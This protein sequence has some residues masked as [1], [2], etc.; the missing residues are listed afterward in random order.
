M[1]NYQHVGL[2]DSRPSSPNKKSALMS[3]RIGISVL[4]FL[5]ISATRV[6]AQQSA[7]ARDFRPNEDPSITIPRISQKIE[8]DGI[9]DDEG[10]RSASHADNFCESYP[11]DCTKP[12]FDMWAKIAYD[13]EN[14]YVSFKLFEDPSNIRRSLSER[15]D[16]WR[17]DYFALVLDT[18]GNSEWAYFLAVNPLGIQGDERMTID[19][20]DGS[21]DVIFKSAGMVT[22]DGYQIEMAIPFK[23]LRYPQLDLQKWKINFYVTQPRS[24]RTRFSWYPLSRDNSCFMCQ[25]GEAK[26][27]QG[28]SVG[29]NVQLLPAITSS[30]GASLRDGD[31]PSSGIK[32]EKINLDP[33]LGIKYGISPNLNLDL[34]LNPD[35][36][37]I[38]AD[39]SQVD[40]NTTF[41][42]FFDERRPFF[43]EGSDLFDT[44]ISTVYT[45]SINNPAFAA[46]LTGRYDKVS[47]GY[48]GGRDLDSPFIIPFEENSAVF[49]GGA[50]FSNIFR[51]KRSLGEGSFLGG[52][53][54]DRRLDE[55]GSGSTFGFD[56]LKRLTSS[57]S[58]G[59]HLVGSYTE[60]PDSPELSENIR[61]QTFGDGYTSALDGETFSGLG[62]SIE[63]GNSGRNFLMETDIKAF[64]PT[65]RVDN[66]FERQNS[67]YGFTTFNAYLF[68]PG[69]SWITTVNPD[70]VAG[71]DWNWDGE[72]K[73]RFFRPGIRLNLR[74][75]TFIGIR[76][77][78]VND[79]KFAGQ[80]FEGLR[81]LSLFLDSSPN[82]FITLGGDADFGPQISRDVD[83]PLKG[84]SLNYRFRSTV[85]PT[86]QLRISPSFVYSKLD[87]RATGE[88]IFSGYIFR[89]R[90]D[91][92]ASRKL[93][94]RV[95]AE[96]NNFSDSFAL[97]PLVTY[98]INAF[99]AVY[100]GST[101]DYFNFE[102]PYGISQSGR[103]FFFK[104]Q[105]LL[106]V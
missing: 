7:D 84:N 59:W 80:T 89:S 60:E 9:L 23:S 76:Y 24:D 64:S 90:F 96:Y 28:I 6:R 62:G 68:R 67:V 51:V 26:G 95:I 14:L 50:S 105:Y 48:I 70:F 71:Q 73:D 86:S 10:W 38:E 35:F 69:N 83:N 65:F 94:L 25:L 16:Q 93:S 72:W 43:Q 78:I 27:L 18:Y 56:G 87:N 15:D 19:N 46:K 37:Q 81:R 33:S 13:S 91:Y 100:F 103:Q 85:R 54:T 106:Q 11:G 12:A 34:A 63:L 58:L 40:V 31:D 57:F 3:K 47:V 29:R 44:E 8:I 42:L 74:G 1:L 92:Q 49:T 104:L 5:C 82:R 39:P 2:G 55:G 32:N 97:D 36:S 17:D 102:E 98:R 99:S 101:L 30:Q 53:I 45:R 20:E 88:E 79:E 61:E 22:D 41:A 52:M 21:F 75:Q 77:H 4:L 66:G